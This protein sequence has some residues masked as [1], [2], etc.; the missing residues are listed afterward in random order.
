MGTWAWPG[1][2][3]SR[4][5]TQQTSSV[6]SIMEDG[7][8]G[9]WGSGAGPLCPSGWPGGSWPAHLDGPAEIGFPIGF[10]AAAPWPLSA[11]FWGG[12]RM[13]RGGGRSP[14]RP[15]AMLA[16]SPPLWHSPSPASSGEPSRKLVCRTSRSHDPRCLCGAWL[17]SAC[18]GRDRVGRQGGPGREP[19]DSRSR[20]AG[21]RGRPH[22]GRGLALCQGPGDQAGLCALRAQGTEARGDAAGRLS[23]AQSGGSW[24]L[25]GAGRGHSGHLLCPWRPLPLPTPQCANPAPS[26]PTRA[27]APLGRGPPWLG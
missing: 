15:S 22:S 2:A 13:P 25:L 21:L 20:G 19:G 3:R 26:E 4:A 8:G 11:S 14:G 5:R 24:P 10:L 9:S 12:G 6:H 17:R 23:P 18:L 16:P 27:H 7:P 1:D